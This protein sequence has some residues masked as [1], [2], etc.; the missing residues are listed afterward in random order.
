MHVCIPVCTRTNT[1]LKRHAHICAVF[2][3]ETVPLF[4]TIRGRSDIVR[5]AHHTAVW[6]RLNLSDW[7]IRKKRKWR[8]MLF[9]SEL[10][11]EW[12]FRG[13]LQKRKALR[14]SKNTRRRIPATVMLPV[15]GKHCPAWV[16]FDKNHFLPTE[17]DHITATSTQDERLM[18]MAVRDATSIV[19]SS[20][21]R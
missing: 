2:N 1:P 3:M 12:A 20:A 5:E 8:Q 11:V 21:E 10:N 17:W 15:C 7:T 14:A 4:C 19:S 6:M 13:L 9:Y 18:L 16:L